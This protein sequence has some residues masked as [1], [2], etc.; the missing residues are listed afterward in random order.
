VAPGTDVTLLTRRLRM[1]A[2]WTGLV[3][4]GAYRAGDGASS[5]TVELSGEHAPGL[6]TVSAAADG[7]LRSADVTL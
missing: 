6:L 3:S 5:V 4:A 7:A 2:A 1:A